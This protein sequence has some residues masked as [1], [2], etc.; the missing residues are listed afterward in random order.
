MADMRGQLLELISLHFHPAKHTT[1]KSAHYRR[2]NERTNITN[3]WLCQKRTQPENP[4]SS[5]WKWKMTLYGRYQ[6]DKDFGTTVLNMNESLMC[7]RSGKNEEK[8][9]A[10]KYDKNLKRTTKQISKTTP[11]QLSLLNLGTI[12]SL[13]IVFKWKVISYS[14]DN[15]NGVPRLNAKIE[16]DASTPKLTI[17]AQL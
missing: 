5:E 11:E 2:R 7:R 13:I 1:I 17:W 6:W 12:Y 3:L 10:N 4:S 15:Q 14:F 9:H 16:L 8:S